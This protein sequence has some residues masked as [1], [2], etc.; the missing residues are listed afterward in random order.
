MA[1]EQARGKAVDRRA[2]IWAFG[3]VLYE[4]LA[5]ERPFMGEDVTDIL[6][7]VVK[8]EPDLSPMPGEMR[9]V[10]ARCLKKNPAERWG[11]IS[12]AR[13]AL[14]HPALPV[15]A[16]AQRAGRPGWLLPAVVVAVAV[17]A[18]ALAW[19]LKPQPARPALV[20][21]FRY[22]LP[23]GQSFSHVERHVLAI[24]P[25]GSE[26]VYTSGDQL[27]LRA[28]NTLGAQRIAGTAPDLYEP[29]F[30]PDGKWIAYFTPGSPLVLQKIPVSGGAPVTLCSLPGGFSDYGISWSGSSIVF[31]YRSG[32][33]SGAIEEV[34]DDGGTP[35][36]V[37]AVPS[38]DQ[39]AQPQLLD[40]GRRLLFTIIPFSGGGTDQ[41]VI[42]NAGSD[43]SRRVLVS[44]GA[45]AHVLPDG[46]MVYFHNGTIFGVRFNASSGTVDGTPVPL[47]VGVSAANAT[48]GGQFAIS[49]NGTL[50]YW[51]GAAGAQGQM[52]Q[53]VW[54]NAQGKETPL[55]A[56]ARNYRYPRVSPDGKLVAVSVQ[57]PDGGLWVWNTVNSTFSRLVIGRANANFNSAWT[58]A[59]RTLYYTYPAKAGG[60]HLYRVAA[61]G[62]SPAV[63]LGSAP[64]PLETITPDG[65][66][67]IFGGV[68]TPQF[69][70]PLQANSAAKLLFGDTLGFAVD[71]TVLSPDGHW[72]AYLS[73]ETGRPEIYVRPWPDIESG[74]WQVSDNYGVY[75]VW[76]PDGRTLYYLAVTT[77]EIMAVPVRL[78][79][80][81]S[82]GT[83]KA[84][85]TYRFPIPIGYADYGVAPGGRFIAIKPGTTAPTGAPTPDSLVIVT[86]WAKEVAARVR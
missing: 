12:D 66:Y 69:G 49:A 62:A 80:T 19:R 44:N 86:H 39:A 54:M 1:P 79:P 14:Q 78:R 17:V 48:A 25:D 82:T 53:L 71:D 11:W 47:V 40:G 42:Q 41:I 77:R 51:P 57:G 15:A 29:V 73:T 84:L 24:S 38:G 68:G 26:I 63:D 36:T 85:F 37:A 81:F 55:G 46:R 33:V 67:G 5:G 20:G 61:D 23:A 18:A 35:Q 13:Y 9:E 64:W 58:S 50:V 4:M 83:Q 34:S 2:D 31:G 32:P 75:P 8:L 7:A 65:S 27:Y 59:G 10:V 21:R 6:A 16:T 74:R 43:A 60:L 30:S 45:N 28:L 70:R 72:L 3:V 56:P 76:S 52:G 22:L